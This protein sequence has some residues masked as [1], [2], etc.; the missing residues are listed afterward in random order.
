MD[1][2]LKGLSQFDVVALL[3][4]KELKGTTNSKSAKSMIAGVLCDKLIEHTGEEWGWAQS[5]PC[6][7][8]ADDAE[9]EESSGEVIGFLWRKSKASLSSC[10]ESG[11]HAQVLLQ[12]AAP[13][14]SY[15]HR[16]PA[17]ARFRSEF[18]RSFEF[19]L[20]AT[21]VTFGGFG[22]TR[23]EAARAKEL[24]NLAGAVE[25][26]QSMEPN[27]CVWCVGDFN[28]NPKEP[29]WDH[30]RNAGWDAHVRDATMVLS[31]NLYDNIVARGSPNHD[32]VPEGLP[33]HEILLDH[34]KLKNVRAR[35]GVINML[36]LMDGM[37]AEQ[38]RVLEG[39]GFDA[40]KTE[41]AKTTDTMAKKA[42]TAH[43]SDHL[44]VRMQVLLPRPKVN[45]DSPRL[46]IQPVQ[47]VNLASSRAKTTSGFD[48]YPMKMLAEN[49]TKTEI[50]TSRGRRATKLVNG[51]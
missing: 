46:D 2:V 19:V 27:A 29:A 31:E 47:G 7:T 8:C 36:R 22:I 40:T 21:H 17:V 28:M 9:S 15:F 42:F 44:P 6:R 11:S 26:I 13:A 45:T 4:L 48:R 18:N 43:V 5:K 49:I 23:N 25:C 30:F 38:S 37:K 35:V 39:F 1:F 34:P 41:V 24:R 3:E 33:G 16:P 12:D 20:V 10:E 51:A 50:I 14:S 32:S